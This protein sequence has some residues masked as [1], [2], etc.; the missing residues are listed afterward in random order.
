MRK[1]RRQ[2]ANRGL[3]HSESDELP[4]DQL[5]TPQPSEASGRP[6]GWLV[7][8]RELAQRLQSSVAIDRLLV[9]GDVQPSRGVHVASR[10]GFL[11]PP[12]SEVG[13]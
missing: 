10:G 2:A 1:P 12:L 13:K 5:D 9:Q 6:P 3:S 4:E 8:V 7:V 11:R